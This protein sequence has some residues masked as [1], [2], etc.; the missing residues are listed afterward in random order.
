MFGVLSPLPS[1]WIIL[2]IGTRFFICQI[3]CESNCMSILINKKPKKINMIKGI[4]GIKRINGDKRGNR[5]GRCHNF[6]IASTWK[7][8]G[9]DWVWEDGSGLLSCF[10]RSKATNP[11]GSPLGGH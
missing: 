10:L 11:T 5:D 6:M 2:L 7:K 1:P 8:I 9:L 3:Y 4:E